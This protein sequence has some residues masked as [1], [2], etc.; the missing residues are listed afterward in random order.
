MKL[1]DEWGTHCLLGGRMLNS[2]NKGKSKDW[3]AWWFP[4]LKIETGGT[5]HPAKVPSSTRPFQIL[6]SMS[7]ISASELLT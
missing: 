7:F 4:G 2:K 1:C 6:D 3:L 5:R